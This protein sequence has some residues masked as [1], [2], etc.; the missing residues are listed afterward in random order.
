[1][2]FKASE[3]GKD[4]M[5]DTG[6]THGGDSQVFAYHYCVIFWVQIRISFDRL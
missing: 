5:V 1:M 4:E 2:P 6:A 3:L